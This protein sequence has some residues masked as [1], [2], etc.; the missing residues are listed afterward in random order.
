[1]VSFNG[2][3]EDCN[4][5]EKYQEIKSKIDETQDVAQNLYSLHSR[6]AVVLILQLCNQ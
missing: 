5:I 2:D 1:M 3:S 4:K 6:L